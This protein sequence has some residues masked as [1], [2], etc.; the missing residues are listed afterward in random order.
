MK[1]YLHISYIAQNSFH[2]DEIFHRKFKLPILVLLKKFVK[3]LFTSKLHRA[4]LELLSFLTRFL[5][6]NSKF[7]FWFCVLLRWHL[8]SIL[9]TFGTNIDL[10][11]KRSRETLEEDGS[12]ESAKKKTKREELAASSA[13]SSNSTSSS[14][15]P[16]MNSKPSRGTRGSLSERADKGNKTSKRSN[17][18]ASEKKGSP[19]SSATNR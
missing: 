16:S 9:D 15:S 4:E 14:N 12:E 17:S 10:P 3:A 1:L 13:A 5:T 11:L 2:F 6:E 8:V 19:P 18:A 7:Q